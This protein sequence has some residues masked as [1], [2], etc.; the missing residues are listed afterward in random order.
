MEILQVQTRKA[1]KF[2]KEFSDL[3]KAESFV[4][5][6]VISEDEAGFF[7]L[8]AK[9]NFYSRGRRSVARSKSYERQ[10]DSLDVWQR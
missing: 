1:E 4:P 7:E 10:V 8:V 2:K 5:Q 3:I 9:S 6:Q